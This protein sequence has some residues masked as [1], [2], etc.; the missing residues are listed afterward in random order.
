VNRAWA[1][2]FGRGIVKTTDDF[3]YQGESPSHPE[4]LDWLALEFMKQ[5]WSMKKLHRLIVTSATYRQSSNVSSELLANDPEN[6]LLAR[7]PRMRLEAEMVRDGALQAAG[8][9]SLKMGGPPVK[10]PQAEGVSEVAYGNPKWD[11]SAGE[12]RHRRSLYTF[13]KRTA[14]FALYN[15]FDAPTGESCIARRDISNT[16]LQALTLLNDITFMEA[17]QAL[18]KQLATQTSDD[19]AR[20]RVA[21]ERILSRSP[22]EAELP[23]L[24]QFLKTQRARFTAG[25]LDPKAF[26]GK[27]ADAEHAAWTALTRALFNLDEA[28]TKS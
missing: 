18:G 16:P 19:R 26:A 24:L 1:A 4:L 11:A 9:L 22:R 27:D 23:R 20:I 13:V 7:F 3:G 15:T 28:V 17:A 14:P 5:G 8:L 21:Y 25:E 12:D 6:R 10:P 2:F